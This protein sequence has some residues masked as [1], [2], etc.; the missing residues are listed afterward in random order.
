ITNLKGIQAALAAEAA[1]V[2]WV[3]LPPVGPHAADPH[4]EHWGVV[5]RSHGAPTWAPIAGTG[6]DGRWTNDDTGLAG[7]VRT[8]LRS[9]PGAGA[10]DLRPLVERL[11]TQRI[12]PLAKALAA[13]A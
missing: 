6:P 1:L 3:D 12:E 2:A 9:R 11:R 13:T 10:A 4:G 8:E 7:R 5:V